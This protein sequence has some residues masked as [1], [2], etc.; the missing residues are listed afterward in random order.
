MILV[1]RPLAAILAVILIAATAAPLA[2]ADPAR[3]LNKGGLTSEPSPELEPTGIT[4]CD[5]RLSA[6][7]GP[8]V[9]ANFSVRAY[10]PFLVWG[11][12]YP[13]DTTV[14]IDFFRVDGSFQFDAVTD[15]AGEFLEDFAYTPGSDTIYP[16]TWS[17]TAE[18]VGGECVDG[19]TLTIQRPYPFTDIDGFENEIAWLYREGITGGCTSTRFCPTNSV[20]RGQMA[21]FLNRALGLPATGSDFFD[22]D[23]GTAFEG[24]INRLAAAGI[25]GGCA[26]R[27]FCPGATVT[28]EQMASFLA[29]AFNLPGATSD[30]FGDDKA[31]IHEG[32]INR[33]AQSGITG[34]CATGRYCPSSHVTREQMAAFLY[35]A[36]SR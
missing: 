22:D 21:A 34:G 32:D 33:L 25:T 19:I 3:G 31:S 10:E 7:D 23:D 30:Y 36:L 15:S 6:V 8:L 17:L 26:T 11:F 9:D 29:R 28:R 24:D 5:V 35:R 18:A 12:S 20:T 2:A 4:A 27:R 14:F 13:A 1:G 16:E